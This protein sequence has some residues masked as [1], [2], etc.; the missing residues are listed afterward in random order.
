M[1]SYKLPTLRSI[2]I[3]VLNRLKSFL[4]RAGTIIL[5]ITV[6]I[7]ALSYYPRSAAVTEEYNIRKAEAISSF[8]QLQ[9]LLASRID[10]LATGQSQVVRSAAEDIAERFDHASDLTQLENMRAELLNEYVSY[11]ELVDAHYRA[12]YLMLNHNQ[13]ITRIA[14]E[15]AGAH[16]RGSFLG[17]VGRHIEPLF[18]PLGWD[19]KITVSVLA[20]FPAR[21]VII[22]T[23]G[24]IYNLG[25]EIEVESSSLIDKMRNAVWEEGP[26]KGRAVFSPAVA[27]S[28]M[29]FFALCC[30]CGA[31]LVTIRQE[32]TRWM[33]SVAT[34]AYMTT[35]AYMF[36]FVSFQILRGVGF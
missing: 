17:M 35:L 27:I 8:T 22:A 16:I 7:W 19:W 34:F 13:S 26:D 21:E 4:L 31:T 12:R 33:Y 23:L 1:P 15:K 11:P 28:I 18:K 6:V 20:A 9:S 30:Q 2:S 24:T 10:A 14:N 29:V 32:T 5:A 25:T 36:A 3:R